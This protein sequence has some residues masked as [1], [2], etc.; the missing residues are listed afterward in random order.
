MRSTFCTIVLNAE[1]DLERKP[2]PEFPDVPW[3]DTTKCIKCQCWLPP[4]FYTCYGNW[5]EVREEG[6]EENET[7]RGD[8]L[9]A[10]MRTR[11]LVWGCN[12]CFADSQL[13]VYRNAQNCRWVSRHRPRKEVKACEEGEQSKKGVK[14]RR[15]YKLSKQRKTVKMDTPS[16][17]L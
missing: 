17:D 5:W 8:D 2:H 1:K 9:N 16:K 14:R 10:F 15:K 7:S 13:Y 4:N 6:N 3:E 12:S 11:C